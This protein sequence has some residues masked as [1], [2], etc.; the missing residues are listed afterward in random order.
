L[1][2]EKIDAVSSAVSLKQNSRN[3]LFS[4]ACTLNHHLHREL[5]KRVAKFAM[6]RLESALRCNC[7]PMP[8]SFSPYASRWRGIVTRANIFLL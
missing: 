8:V 2:P 5:P 3:E 1:G 4:A 7:F 6:F